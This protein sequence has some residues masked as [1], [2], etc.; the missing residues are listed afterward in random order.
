MA[1]LVIDEGFFRYKKVSMRGVRPG[2]IIVD[3]AGIFLLDY[4]V[5]Q[6]LLGVSVQFGLLGMLI[7]NH[8]ANK[9]KNK[10]LNEFNQMDSRQVVESD[11]NSF[12]IP[13]EGISSF[14]V[15][16]GVFSRWRGN[17][18]VE[19]QADENYAL[20]VPNDVFDG[21]VSMIR[22]KSPGRETN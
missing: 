3:D 7:Y 10:K 19:I 8:F 6:W 2:R 4:G 11:T 18:Q 9:Q 1:K 22:S 14:T 17:K 16:E 21:L 13:F 15:R 12:F 20:Y 5:A